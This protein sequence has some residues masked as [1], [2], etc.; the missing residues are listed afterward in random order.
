MA[1]SLTR[2]KNLM[3]RAL[4][5]YQI[6]GILGRGAM[7]VVYKGFDTAIE[8]TVALKTVRT[9]LL[10]GQEAD[11]WLA[12]FRQEARAAG[13]CFHPNIVAIFD[14]GEENGLPYIAMEYI[15]GREL[16]HH[17][18]VAQ[19]PQSLQEIRSIVSQV[20]AAL[21]Y[22]HGCG[23]VHRDIKPAN[24][25]LFDDGRVK[26]ADFGIARLGATGLTKMG[27]MIGTPAYMAPEQV[28]GLEVDGRADLFAIG[29]ILY[30]LLGGKRPFEGETVTEIVS[31][32]VHR[33]PLA[34]AQSGRSYSPALEAVV[35]RALA[36]D[37]EQRFQSAA[38][39]A[40]AL[41][42]ALELS[43]AQS[44]LSPAGRG[45]TLWND[46]LLKRAE[47]TLT[48]YLGPVARQVVKR[49]ARDSL[50]LDDLIQRLAAG[51]PDQERER[52]IRRVRA[53]ETGT[54][55][56]SLSDSASLPAQF[57]PEVLSAIQQRLTV[58]V[59]PIAKVLVK[60]AARR[61]TTVDDLYRQLAEHLP[62]EEQEAFLGSR[63]RA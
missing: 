11:E 32:V 59:G 34:L 15:E 38:Q 10:D 42:D 30:E 24:I 61:S 7:G 54:A 51:L 36:K 23:V 33:E 29:V 47:E 55:V 41:D 31:Q 12:R 48:H 35:A 28:M 49:A 62:E 26:V 21:G 37:P 39:F 52:F 56:T 6:R 50:N 27:S 2:Q 14:Y 53:L 16:R 46:Q 19:G 18:Q 60:K 45:G 3:P 8:R 17:L 63:P 4:G 40:A 1:D 57:A 58:H 5:K 25:I 44:S 20:L 13:R 22:A 43:G 9:D